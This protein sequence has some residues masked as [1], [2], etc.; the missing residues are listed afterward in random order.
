MIDRSRSYGRQRR[1]SAVEKF[2]IIGAVATVIGTVASVIAIGHGF[3]KEDGGTE[4]AR[5]RSANVA[6]GPGVSRHGSAVVAKNT[7]FSLA[8]G[9]GILL[10]RDRGEDAF[11][12]SE[13]PNGRVRPGIIRVYF[14]GMRKDIALGETVATS[15]DGCFVWI[16]S[17]ASLMEEITRSAQ[18]IFEYHCNR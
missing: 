13:L 11:A 4:K 14:N 9:Q 5:L 18:W 3:L 15:D 7:R 2:S 1:Y 12:L 10:Q 17:E 6:N 16:V 8:V